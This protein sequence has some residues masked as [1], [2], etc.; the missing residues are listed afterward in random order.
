[1]AFVILSVRMLKSK[2]LK[3]KSPNLAQG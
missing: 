3:V 1:L 2:R